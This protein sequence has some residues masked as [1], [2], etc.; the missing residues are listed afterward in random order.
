MLTITCLHS[1]NFKT[2]ADKR[3]CLVIGSLL[4]RVF[5]LAYQDC[6]ISPV[7]FLNPHTAYFS[8]THTAAER[9][10][11]NALHRDLLPLHL[12]T[13]RVKCFHFSFSGYAFALITARLHAT[14]G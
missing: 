1:G 11:Y 10:F 13:M 12:A 5:A 8:L 7:D 4:P 9:E 2:V 3:N 14:D 6:F